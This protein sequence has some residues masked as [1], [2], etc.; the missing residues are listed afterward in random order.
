M[1]PAAQRAAPPKR[2]ASY[3][4]QEKL[5]AANALEA[6][7]DV[8]RVI[9]ERYPDLS[10]SAY[11]SRRKL[12][13]KWLRN[14]PKIEMQ[15]SL[16]NGSSKKKAWPAGVG[17]KLHLEAEKELVV[18]VNDLRKDG[19]PISTKMLALQAQ[20]LATE[21]DIESFSASWRWRRAF[22]ARHKLSMR[23]RTRTGQKTPAD[24]NEI[25]AAFALKVKATILD[26]GLSFFEFHP[27]RT[28][29]T[30]G[31]K[32]VWVRCAGK[33]NER[34]SMKLLGDSGGIKY[35]PFIVFKANPSKIPETEEENKRL[36]YGFGKQIWRDIG[37]VHREQQ[38][39]IYG[40]LKG[41]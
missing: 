28:L 22:Q 18:W 29:S 9:K 32:L 5:D 6:T 31:P 33:T 37:V 1:H 27:T 11:E 14:K 24:L 7:K 17:T 12:V 3:T 38:L 36:R 26:L 39:E 35:R 30:K 2:R 40:N 4:T 13:L 8:A 19:V 23:A 10:A 41:W 16:K 21:N 15:C 34:A 20:D 25:A